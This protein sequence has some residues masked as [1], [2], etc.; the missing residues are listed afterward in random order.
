MGLMRPR[1]TV[2]RVPIAVLAIV[3]L[4]SSLTACGSAE[5]RKQRYYD[6][7]L[8]YLDAHKYD[9]AALEFRNALQIDP[10]FTQA[11]LELGRTAERMGDPRA[12]LGQY[13]AVVDAEPGNVQARV[14]E[15]RLLVVGGYP[16]RA[17][18]LV[19]AALS[20]H[21]D[22]AGLLTV[23]G[24][25]RA[26]LGDAAGAMADA[27]EAYK[28]APDDDYVVALLASVLKR[29]GRTDQ[30]ISV[31]RD[32]LRNHSN[33]VDLNWVLADVLEARGDYSGAEAQL[34]GLV[35]LE[36]RVMSHRYELARFYLRRKNVDAAE[37]TLRS[38]VAA[39]PKSD[40]PILALVEF[41]RAQRGESLADAT[42][43]SFAAKRP[44]D[45]LLQLRRIESL[46]R[47][48]RPDEAEALSRNV[49]ARAG[50][51]PEGLAARDVLAAMLLEQGKTSDAIPL[52]DYVIKSNARDGR[53]LVLRATIELDR[54]D[55]AAAVTDLRAEL[56]GDPNSVVALR[57]LARA[58]AKQG[59][60]PLAEDSLRTALQ[61]NT[62]DTAV[63]FELA[64]L[65]ERA[66]KGAQAE[67]AVTALLADAPRNVPAL[68][69]LFRLEAARKDYA[70]ARAT[71]AAVTRAIPNQ[72][73]GAY[74]LGTIDQAER[75][76]GAAIQDYENALALQPDSIEPLTALIDLQTSHQQ[77]QAAMERLDWV[78]AK[79]PR[80]YVAYNLKGQLLTTQGKYPQA[81]AAF[82]TAISL[83]PEWWVPYQNLAR[84]QT[85]ARDVR[86][87][88][89]TLAKGLEQ[90]RYNLT[91][92]GELA[93]LYELL[94]KPD[95]AIEVYEGV[96]SHDAHSAAA[97]SSLALLLASYRSDSRSLMRAKLL[98]SELESSHDPAFEDT[99][100]WVR[101]K[102]GDYLQALTVLEEASRGAPSSALVRYHLG[103]AQLRTGDVEDG[104]LNIQ[105]AV[106]SR[107]PFVG[108]ADAKATLASLG[109]VG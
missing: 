33:S 102:T 64:E 108:V 84:A 12:A 95:E 46:R 19:A 48:Q 67:A 76:T 73:L 54:G 65:L 74:L 31:L 92:A 90:T 109:H 86:A 55:T 56:R 34:V 9:K 35:N 50:D 72:G 8:S 68:E 105:R 60:L 17:V 52:I 93:G 30:A 24:A 101:F 62:K 45:Y 23:R 69:L 103:M 38:A 11:R 88:T 18:D 32:A 29:G 16:R 104:R 82:E 39:A 25:A 66:G 79:A 4:V 22:D 5:S 43:A 85:K 89:A 81:T 75:K 91:L 36:P 53:A 21:P 51:G 41:Q 78:I 100:G 14:L 3:V 106:D 49:I 97:A 107:R 87:S 77:S 13:Q 6:R 47:T 70:N 40:E 20:T 58:Y 96:V 83:K 80:D 27:S 7:G 57:M 15:G 71:A 1:S 94:G 2:L 98:A 42:L 63:R 44:D 37:R 59:D 99:V 26:Q 28:H 10:H 61:A